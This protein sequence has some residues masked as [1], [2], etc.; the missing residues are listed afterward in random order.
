MP[1]TVSRVTQ[2]AVTTIKREGGEDGDN[3]LLS[4]SNATNN[5]ANHSCMLQEVTIEDALVWELL[6]PSRP[7]A[8]MI[9]SLPPHLAVV[10]L[11][12]LGDIVVTIPKGY[13]GE[14]V[15]KYAQ[16]ILQTPLFL[17]WLE[18][19]YLN[20]LQ[21]ENDD[22]LSRAGTVV[23]TRSLEKVVPRTSTMQ[24]ERASIEAFL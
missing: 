3:E 23:G 17:R 19:R 14:E 4:L 1:P 16:I 22:L 20:D 24:Q 5:T 10:T 15:S 6:A 18:K 21:Q 12:L 8:A 2:R 7:P 11:P 13:T 9:S